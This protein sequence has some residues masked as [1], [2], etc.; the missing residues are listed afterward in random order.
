MMVLW[1]IVGFIIGFVYRSVLHVLWLS[2]AIKESYLELADKGYIMRR[3][4]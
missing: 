4:R 3:I 1:V 2:K